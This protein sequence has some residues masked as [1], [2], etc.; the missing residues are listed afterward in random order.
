MILKIK[1]ISH[2]LSADNLPYIYTNINFD[3]LNNIIS[4]FV[5]LH[6]LFEPSTFL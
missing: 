3:D 5:N 1:E 6:H 2:I 4:L